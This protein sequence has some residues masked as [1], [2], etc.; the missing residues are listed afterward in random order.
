VRRGTT[1]IDSGSSCIAQDGFRNPLSDKQ[2][3]RDC[4]KEWERIL[5]S[6]GLNTIRS[7]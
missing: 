1:P 6:E 7:S 5:Q 3:A 4:V 2:F